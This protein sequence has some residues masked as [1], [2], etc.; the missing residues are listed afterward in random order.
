MLQPNSIGIVCWDSDMRSCNELRELRGG[1]PPQFMSS[2]CFFDLLDSTD[3]SF[4]ICL[5]ILLH[6]PQKPPTLD[7]TPYPGNLNAAG[8]SDT[9]LGISLFCLSLDGWKFS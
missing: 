5:Y 4:L 9:P 8:E 6:T 3:L 2:T 1:K 7:Q